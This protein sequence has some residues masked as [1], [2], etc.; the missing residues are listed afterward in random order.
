MIDIRPTLPR[1]PPPMNFADIQRHALSH[2]GATEAPHHE[3]TSF[4]VGGKIFATVPPDQKHLHVFVDEWDRASAL[5]AD[6]SHVEPLGWG[7]KVVGL[8]ISLAGADE[9]LIKRLLT[10]AWGRKASPD[11]IT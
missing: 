3:L 2:A 9:E 4:R 10:R 7:G 6:P 5:A 1:R 11:V 8:R